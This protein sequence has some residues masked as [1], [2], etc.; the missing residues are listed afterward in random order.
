[1]LRPR[2]PAQQGQAL[3]GGRLQQ[4]PSEILYCGG[5]ER[6]FHRVRLLGEMSRSRDSQATEEPIH[7]CAECGPDRL[8]TDTPSQGL[9]WPGLPEPAFPS[10]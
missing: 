9:P 3:D 2:A 8:G 6:L 1:M 7:R 5:A 10:C 4:S